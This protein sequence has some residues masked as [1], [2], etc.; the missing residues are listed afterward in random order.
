MG[1]KKKLKKPQNRQRGH[2]GRSG[3]SRRKDEGSSGGPKDAESCAGIRNE[4]PWSRETGKTCWRMLL[5]TANEMDEMGERGSELRQDTLLPGTERQQRGSRTGRVR[6]LSSWNKN[7]KDSVSFTFLLTD[8]R[9]ISGKVLYEVK[10]S[11][12]YVCV[13]VLPLCVD[14]RALWRPVQGLVLSL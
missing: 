7:K 8:N 5:E 3:E 10:H 12:I 6:K 14:R 13:C 1:E 2:A 9:K 4:M 11:Y